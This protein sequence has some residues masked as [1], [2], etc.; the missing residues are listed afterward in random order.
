VPNHAGNMG[1]I[2]VALIVR[3]YMQETGARTKFRG[4]DVADLEFVPS[5]FECSGCSNHCEVI[6]VEL[7]DKMIAAWGDRC[8]KWTNN[9]I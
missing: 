7:D 3:D 5:S 6:K 2:G 9:T 4:F 1:S 8:G